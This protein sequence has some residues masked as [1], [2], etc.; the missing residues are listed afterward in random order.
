MGAW[1]CSLRRRQQKSSAFFHP[2]EGTPHASRVPKICQRLGILPPIHTI[3]LDSHVGEGDDRTRAEPS[4]SAQAHGL[5]DD[6]TLLPT[7]WNILGPGD[8]EP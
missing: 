6:G 7:P 1:C 2:S 3:N 4:Q 5:H 8:L